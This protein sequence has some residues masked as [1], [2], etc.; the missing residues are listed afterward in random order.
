MNRIAA[1]A[2]IVLVLVLALGAGTVLFLGE[3]VAGS[4]DWVLFPGSPHVY[5]GGKIS[6]GTIVDREGSLLADLT[7]GRSYSD[8]KAVR[9]ST[10]HWVGDR[11]GNIQIPVISYYAQELVGYDPVGGV[12]TYGDGQGQIEL[13]LSA[14]LQAAALE[15]LGDK[16][17]TVAVYNYKTG[18]IL[19]AVST[20]TFDPDN[21]PDING[22]TTGAYTGVYVNRFLQSKYIP[23]SIFKV[24]TLAAALETLPDAQEMTFYCEGKYEINNG[25]ITCEGIHGVQTLKEAFCN[26]CNCAFAQ[27]AQEIGK[28]KLSRYVELFGVTQSVSFDGITTVSGN[29]NVA[30]AS[31]EQFAWSAI[32]QHTDQVN[33]CSFLTFVGALANGGIGMQPYVVSE[34]S[35]GGSTTYEAKPDKGSRVVSESTA[36]VIREYMGNNVTVKYGSENFHGLTVCAKT[37]TGEVGGGKMPNAMFVG[38]VEDE[39]YP[40]AFIVAV[41]EGGY[42]SRTCIPVISII[43]QAYLTHS[44]GK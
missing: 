6:A 17:G 4:R 24:V 5:T 10:L 36:E 37:G 25:D 7:K 44:W 31:G 23:G 29:Y 30:G 20:P 27:L 3:Y 39:A 11:Q 42:G 28:E 19:C 13:T 35:V 22:D 33:P 34:V 26:S 32:G 41:E 12:Y 8:S 2:M 9:K 38:F 43:L 40:L 16:R 1:R 15:A 14:Q 18:E 21:V